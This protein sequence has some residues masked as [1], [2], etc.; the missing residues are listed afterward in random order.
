M[1][2]L[3][4][5][6]HLVRKQGGTWAL[7][8]CAAGL[9]GTGS[10]FFVSTGWLTY[11][12]SWSVLG[13]LVVACSPSRAWVFIACL[14]EPFIDERFILGLPLVFV[15]RQVFLDR[16]RDG[17]DRQSLSQALR[18][19]GS[20]SVGIAPYL[21]LRLIDVH[22]GDGSFASYMHTR[23]HELSDVP[24][25]LYARF[26]GVWMGLRAGWAL[27][28]ALV[29]VVCLGRPRGPAVIAAVVLGVLIIFTTVLSQV[30]AADTGRSASI[31]WPAAVVGLMVIM[32]ARP[33]WARQALP[34]LLGVNLILPASYVFLNKTPP[35]LYFYAQLKACRDSAHVFDPSEWLN[36]ADAF[37]KQNQ[38]PQALHQL[39]IALQL[40]DRLVG[41]WIDRAIVNVQLGNIDAAAHDADAA[42]GLDPNLPDALFVRG[43]AYYHQHDI[44]NARRFFEEA[45]N[46]SAPDWH[47]RADCIAALKATRQ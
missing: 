14:L 21:L 42:L 17:V 46:A 32:R 18:D 39:D 19:L 2:L 23:V 37:M 35:L 8:F 28:I 22:R 34:A 16:Y 10:W 7:A 31:L 4:Y 3:A 36:R 13:L 29:I 9:L 27:V 38:W 20:I 6:A 25:S 12:D 15:L 40:D 24:I 26:L 41:G 33:N 45:L 11:A 47:Y 30:I 1:V 44:T 5:M 43:I